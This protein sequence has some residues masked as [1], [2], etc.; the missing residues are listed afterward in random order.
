M[1]SVGKSY[2]AGLALSE[3]LEWQRGGRLESGWG[4][5]YLTH[6]QLS[7]VADW[8]TESQRRVEEAEEKER[9]QRERVLRQARLVAIVIGVAFL[10][11]VALGVYG[12]FQ[13][14]EAERQRH[15]AEEQRNNVNHQSKINADLAKSEK[16]QRTVAEEQRTVEKQRTVAEEQKRLD[17]ARVESERQAASA[18]SGRLAATALLNKANRPDLAALLSLEG[19][20]A[21][22]LFEARNALLLSLQARPGLVSTLYGASFSCVAFSAD[23][24]LLASASEDGTVRLWDV[25]RRQPLGDGLQGHSSL[26]RSVAFSPDGK[27][28]ASAS[29][30]GTV[31]LWE[32][33]RR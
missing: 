17:V 16:T 20:R 25:T 12:Y 11:A 9:R 28:L 2:L 33:A 19:R 23:G 24:K 6:E 7:R 27:L 10:I 13:K 5:R 26:V 4:S 15:N 22:D 30:D 32:V 21:A 8:V 18:T 31:R 1:D 29:H 3:A 14:G